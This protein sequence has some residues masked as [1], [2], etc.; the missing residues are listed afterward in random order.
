VCVCVCAV[1]CCAVLCYAVLCV[2]ARGRACVCARAR[3]RVLVRVF[4]CVRRATKLCAM[5]IARAPVAS[6]DEL[7]DTH[8]A[9]VLLVFGLLVWVAML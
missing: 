8:I 2:C 3:A 6:G 7:S 1:L 9:C 4:V 5:Q